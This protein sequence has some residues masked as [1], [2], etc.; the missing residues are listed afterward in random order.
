MKKY[1]SI[2]SIR[3]L[4]SKIQ[5]FIKSNIMK[6][7]KITIGILLSFVTIGTNA[8]LKV[9]SNGKIGLKTSSVNNAD[10]QMNIEPGENSGF[11][12]YKNVWNETALKFTTDEFWTF[13]T[14]KKSTPEN[15]IGFLFGAINVGDI[16]RM[17]EYG[18]TLN[19]NQSGGYFPVGLYANTFTNDGIGIMS[20]HN[21]STTNGIS[22]YSRVWRSTSIP[23]ASGYGYNNYNFYVKG[24]G[25]AY[26]N[27]ILITSDS[28]LKT[29]IKTIES[30]LQKIM[31]MRGVTYKYKKQECDITE[32]VITKN[33]NN[34]NI[35]NITDTTDNKSKSHQPQTDKLPKLDESIMEKIAEEDKKMERIG[36][37]AQEMEKIIPEVVRTSVNGT[38]A[39]SYT[40]LIPLL[41]EGMKE[42]QAIIMELQQRI[43]SIESS[44]LNINKIKQSTTSSGLLAS[45]ET[46]SPVLYQ[47]IPNPFS[48]STLIRYSLPETVA[49]AYL[50]IYDMQGKQL[51][52]IAIAER[53]ESSQ[54][55]SGSQFGP[56]IYLYALLADGKEVDVKRMI[57]T[58]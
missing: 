51:K 35:K 19:V 29:D 14:D 42:Q 28:T 38:K 13:L 15:G 30:P 47:N 56:G 46:L 33:A 36:F 43:T 32:N 26:T 24:D 10:I 41:V 23:F 39:I 45:N 22:I 7:K 2:S 4:Q 5:V 21:S 52:Q 16:S 34:T 12:I 8:Q 48:Q 57:L 18:G 9:L 37:L 31:K 40:D 55:I 54:T 49:T 3:I 27:G 20:S 1:L 50:C 17:N 6:I 44:D 58:E 53:G 25:T 11:C